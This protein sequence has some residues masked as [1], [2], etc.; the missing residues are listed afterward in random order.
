[1]ERIN[2]KIVTKTIFDRVDELLDAGED[3]VRVEVPTSLYPCTLKD[4]DS[5]PLDKVCISHRKDVSGS[6]LVYRGVCIQF[7]SE[8]PTINFVT[9]TLTNKIKAE[10]VKLDTENIKHIE[11]TQA[12]VDTLRKEIGTNQPV[13]S[14][15]KIP[16]KVVY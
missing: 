9:K 15:M 4:S 14:F 6:Y 10:I 5:V 7:H 1:M 12:E 16:V 2:M 8:Y 11:L 3:I 13:I